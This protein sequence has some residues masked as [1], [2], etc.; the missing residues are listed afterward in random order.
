VIDRFSQRYPRVILRVILAEQLP[1]RDRELRQR[2]IEVAIGSTDGL[3]PDADTE[4]E[5][6]FDDAQVIVASA[7]SKWAR[8]RGVVRR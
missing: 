6:L 2:N 8:R 4:T 7:Q 5:H 1:L 3:A